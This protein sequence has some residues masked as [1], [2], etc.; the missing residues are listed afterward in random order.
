MDTNRAGCKIIGPSDYTEQTDPANNDLEDSKP[1]ST[2]GSSG[3]RKF[4]QKS[5]Y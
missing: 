1:F 4:T 5:T 3:L 2:K